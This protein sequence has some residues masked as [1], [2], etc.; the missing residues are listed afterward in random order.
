M[1]LI[2]N[3][4]WFVLGGWALFILYT[5]AAIIFFPAFIPLFRLARYAAW[6]FGRGIVT[7]NQL[8][9]FRVINGT[10]TAISPDQNTMRNISGV[11]NV[12]W[13]LTFGWILAL[14]H[15]VS[16]IANLC[17]FWLIVT[18]P[19]ISGN[20]KLMPIALMPFNKVIVP[21]AIET[22]IKLALS[23]SRLNI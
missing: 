12:V 6:P 13:L 1:T 23:K 8:S 9:Q 16:S 3:I 7:Q 10:S 5:I 11:L 20:W 17:F 15:L 21:K 19:N 2:G 22:E 14:A 4:F 18:I